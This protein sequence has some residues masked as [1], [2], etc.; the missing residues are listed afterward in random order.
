[1]STAGGG[2]ARGGV[3]TSNKAATRLTVQVIDGS[4]LRTTADIS[5]SIF[6]I[7]Q[8]WT[9]NICDRFKDKLLFSKVTKMPFHGDGYLIS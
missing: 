3:I 7:D 1:M 9:I 6:Q 5:I 8:S 2:G 4:F